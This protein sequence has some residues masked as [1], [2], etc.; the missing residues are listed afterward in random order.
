MKINKYRLL[1]VIV[2][3]ILICAIFAENIIKIGLIGTLFIIGIA[4]VVYVAI[5]TF[6]EFIFT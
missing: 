2:L 1:E 4:I 3:V 5:I 6:L